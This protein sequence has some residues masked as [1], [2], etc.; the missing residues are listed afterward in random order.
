MYNDF[1]V[2]S[3][4]IEFDLNYALDYL[5]T[6]ENKFIH[7]RWDADDN[8]D[9]VSDAEYQDNISGVYGWGIQSNL[10]DVSTPCPPYAYH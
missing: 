8:L 2:K 5:H 3:L 9:T 6:L 4:D 7:L 10:V 1:L